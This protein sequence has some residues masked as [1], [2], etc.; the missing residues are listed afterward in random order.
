MAEPPEEEIPLEVE[1]GG[2]EEPA[3]EPEA[4]NELQNLDLEIEAGGDEL[5]AQVV[6][7]DEAAAPQEGGLALDAP[8][9]DGGL[10]FEEPGLG[11]AA[12]GPPR[13]PRPARALRSPPPRRSRPSRRKPLHRSPQP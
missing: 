1:E 10:A 8:A 11:E 6:E 3:L 9:G 4:E 2:L 7:D 13:R 12:P 5:N